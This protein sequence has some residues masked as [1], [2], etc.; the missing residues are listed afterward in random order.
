MTEPKRP[1]PN[2]VPIA[3]DTVMP[4]RRSVRWGATADSPPTEIHDDPGLTRAYLAGLAAGRTEAA[5]D[6]D[7]LRD[8]RDRLLDA[9]EGLA[10]TARRYSEWDASLDDLRRALA[11]FDTLTEE[12]T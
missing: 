9:A 7:R 4:P 8:E 11:V 1:Y 5:A 12:K 6:F 2:G 10:V 3:P